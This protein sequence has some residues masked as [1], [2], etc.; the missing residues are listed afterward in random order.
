MGIP[1]N[2]ETKL[3]RRSAHAALDEVRNVLQLSKSAA[4][5]WL[6]SA[7]EMTSDQC[8]IGKFDKATCEMVVDVCAKAVDAAGGFH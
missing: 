6:Q 5:R 1:A 7:M 3:A 8:H 4:Y 2:R